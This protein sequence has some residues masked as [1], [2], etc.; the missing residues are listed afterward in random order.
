MKIKKLTQKNIKPYGWIIDRSFIKDDGQG[1]KYDILLKERSGGWRIGYLIL[2][3]KK[4]VKLESHPDSLETFE[5]VKGKA[6]IALA[7]D[8]TPEKCEM[9]LLDRPVVLKKGIW[10]NV[11]AISKECEIKI[12]ENA[13]VTTEYYMLRSAIRAK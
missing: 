12:F 2:R 9:F 11:T 8:K 3:N 5:P 7:S 13:E 10:H 4:I 6:A 1:D